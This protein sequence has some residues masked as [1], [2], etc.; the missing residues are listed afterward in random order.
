MEKNCIRIAHGKSMVNTGVNP[1]L[2][3]LL[4]FFL[5]MGISSCKNDDDDLTKASLMGTEWTCVAWNNEDIVNICFKSNTVE[6]F[7]TKDGALKGSVSS[8]DYKY[9]KDAYMKDGMVLSFDD[10]ILNGTIL[11]S[12][13]VSGDLM[14]VYRESWIT[15]SPASSSS[16]RPVYTL[17]RVK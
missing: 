2:A 14:E 13:K 16:P 6:C 3:M 8:C 11:K 9:I 5:T 7:L 12:A 10:L 17:R 4:V 15:A 1:V